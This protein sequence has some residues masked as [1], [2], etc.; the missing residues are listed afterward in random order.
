MTDIMYSYAILW[1]QG[2]QDLGLLSNLYWPEV[3]HELQPDGGSARVHTTGFAVVR[4]VAP[5]KS[6]PPGT[7][8]SGLIWKWGLCRCHQGKDGDEN[9]LD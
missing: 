4:T 3:S 1:F 2:F 9:T 5:R 6:C 8:E 7:S